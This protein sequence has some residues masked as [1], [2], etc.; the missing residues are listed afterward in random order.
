MGSNFKDINNYS[1]VPTE[2]YLNLVRSDDCVSVKSDSNDKQI[3]AHNQPP[4][5]YSFGTLGTDKVDSRIVESDKNP[6]QF[7]EIEVICKNTENSPEINRSP[8]LSAKSDSL[9]I[10]EVKVC[11]SEAS[12]A[13][14]RKC[15]S[16]IDPWNDF[17][18][19]HQK[20]IS[21]AKHSCL[22]NFLYYLL[23]ICGHVFD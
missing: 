5:C 15:E 19:I 14:T 13:E 12:T 7:H 1:Y 21:S 4:I 18:E 3:Q 22:D 11:I 23:S 20:D 2:T 9:D 16:S 6:E 17:D 10:D 8:N